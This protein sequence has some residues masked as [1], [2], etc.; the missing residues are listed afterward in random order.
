MLAYGKPK[1]S[2][3]RLRTGSLNAAADPLHEVAEKKDVVYLREVPEAT[4]TALL[5]AGEELRPAAHVRRY[6]PEVGFRFLSRENTGLVRC[7]EGLLLVV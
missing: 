6:T 3:T 7:G 1:S 4:E 5:E 2:V